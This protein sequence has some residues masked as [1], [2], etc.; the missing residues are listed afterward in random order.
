MTNTKFYSLS[1]KAFWIFKRNPSENCA[2]IL[3]LC[4]I[5]DIQHIRTSSRCFR[6]TRNCSELLENSHN[7]QCTLIFAPSVLT[8]FILDG[9]KGQSL[10]LWERHLFRCTWETNFKLQ[11]CSAVSIKNSLCGIKIIMRGKKI[12]NCIFLR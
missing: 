5:R 12:Q 4:I 1:E 11:Q 8:P 3:H 7:R 10:V 2:Q 9:D 6:S